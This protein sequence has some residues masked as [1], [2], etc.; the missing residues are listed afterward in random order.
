MLPL[1]VTFPG[2]KLKSETLVTLVSSPKEF[3]AERK[4]MGVSYALVDKGV[5]DGM[6]NAIPEVFKPV[7]EDLSKVVA[8]YTLDSLPPLRNI[9]HHIDLVAGASFPNLPHY[10]M[11]PKE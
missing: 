5:K 9:Q 6:D 2:K 8:D 7:L 11:S 3:Q 10:R 4:E 1:G